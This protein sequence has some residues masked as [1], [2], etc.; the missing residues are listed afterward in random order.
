[1]PSGIEVATA[2]R[3]GMGFFALIK[4]FLFIFF[5]GMIFVNFVNIAFIQ[6][7]MPK[8]L[9]YLGSNFVKVTENLQNESLKLI[10]VLY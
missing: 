6:K 3:T 7:D 4:M 5:F 1:M 2:T 10:D 9:E 8:G